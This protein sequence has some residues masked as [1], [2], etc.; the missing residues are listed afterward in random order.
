MIS[1]PPVMVEAVKKALATI[2]IQEGLIRTD[3]F[4]GYD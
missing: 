2:S 3:M 4:M 1:G